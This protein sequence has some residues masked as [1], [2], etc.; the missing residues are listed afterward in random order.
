MDSGN[1]HWRPQSVLLWIP[2]EMHWKSSGRFRDCYSHSSSN[3]A[4]RAFQL[5]IGFVMFGPWSKLFRRAEISIDIYRYILNPTGT[6][7]I[8]TLVGLK[9]YFDQ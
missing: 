4:W 7:C 6:Y 5:P 1:V 2:F 3:D 8:S 9:L